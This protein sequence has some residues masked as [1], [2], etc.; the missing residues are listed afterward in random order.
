MLAH[1]VDPL[2]GASKVGSFVHYQLKANRSS[3]D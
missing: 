1:D 3:S 2:I